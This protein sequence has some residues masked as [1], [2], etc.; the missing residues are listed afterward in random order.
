MAE[1]E[2][3]CGGGTKHGLISPVFIKRPEAEPCQ[4]SHRLKA[5]TGGRVKNE[6]FVTPAIDRK[7]CG[8]EVTGRCGGPVLPPAKSCPGEFGLAGQY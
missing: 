4:I 8:V 5:R 3:A 2:D 7:T 6:V 1:C